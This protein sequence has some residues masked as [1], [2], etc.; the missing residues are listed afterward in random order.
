ML[1]QNISIQ[2]KWH[3]CAQLVILAFVVTIFSS[4]SKSENADMSFLALLGG[5]AGGESLS[6]NLSR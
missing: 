4:C 6:K 1:T 5:G 3:R 2:R